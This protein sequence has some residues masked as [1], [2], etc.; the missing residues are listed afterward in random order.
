MLPWIREEK[1]SEFFPGEN[2]YWEDWMRFK[3]VI[4][5]AATIRDAQCQT[6]CNCNKTDYLIFVLE[7]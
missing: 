2:P 3:C 1:V 6:I 4:C 7:S 5:G